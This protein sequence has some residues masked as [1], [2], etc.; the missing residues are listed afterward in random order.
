[1]EIHVYREGDD[2][3]DKCTARRLE[4]DDSVTVHSSYDR[5]PTGTLLDPFAERALSPA[6]SSP[7]VAVDSSWESADTVFDDLGRGYER[8]ALPYLVAVNPVNYGKPFRLNTA[9]AVGAAVYVLGDEELSRRLLSYFSY[10]ET[11]LQLNREPLERY[12]ECEDSE[13]VVAVQEEYLSKR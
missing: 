5:L 7:V 12:A 2:D 3:P 6:D 1:M 4:K 11:F 10:G 13:E 8:R 9:E